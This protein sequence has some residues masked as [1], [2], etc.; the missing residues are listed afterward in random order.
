MTVGEPWQRVGVTGH[1]DLPDSVA[2]LVL[3]KLNAWFPTAHHTWVI[4]SLAQGADTFVA[5]HLLE[6]GAK[7]RVIVPSNNY[8]TSFATATAKAT[9]SQLL[10][11]ADEVEVLG[12]PEPNEEAYMAAGALVAKD[13]DWLIAIWDGKKAR[14]LGGTGDVVALARSYGKDVRVIWPTGVER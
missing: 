6:R 2:S 12:Y 10:D 14:G 1:Q 11:R 4:C 8:E 13:S 5:A 3:T 7:L 9:Y